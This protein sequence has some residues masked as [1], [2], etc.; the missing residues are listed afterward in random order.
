MY[1]FFGVCTTLVNIVSYYIFS[2][3]L[4]FSV[5]SSTIIAWILG[6][7]FAY[8]TN[9]KWVFESRATTKKEILAEM[10]SFFSC[11]L[12]T[13]IVDWVGM[14]IFAEKLQFNDV[15]VKIILNIIDI[16]LNYVFSKLIV[17]SDKKGKKNKLDK[18]EIVIYISLLIV[19]F[20]FMFNSPL[21]I[22]I[23]RESGTDSSVFRTIGMM[24]KNGF[25]PYLQSFDH[26]GPLVYLYNYLEV[27]F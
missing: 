22:W 15:I 9:R 1:L 27:L 3:P 26:K 13:G 25:L 21:H 4:K 7:L 10:T 5:L 16:I 20:V 6:V 11:R 2:H 8:F 24:M 14:Y 18:K 23:G 12:A 19:V 17:F